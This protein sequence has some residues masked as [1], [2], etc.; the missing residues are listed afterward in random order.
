MSVSTS[1]SASSSSAALTVTAWTVDQFSVVKV[2][3]VLPGVRP[4]PVCP[5]I[6]T[7]TVS[8]GS[9]ASDTS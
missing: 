3:L 2:R 5:E 8:E 1:S 4:V 6:V 9:V 7:V